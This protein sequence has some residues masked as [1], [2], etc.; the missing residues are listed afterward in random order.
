M[1][2]R[3]EVSF[4][5][6]C[7]TPMRHHKGSASGRAE[8]REALER[9]FPELDLMEIEKSGRQQRLHTEDILDACVA[10]WS[11]RRLVNKQGR[12]LPEVVP[13]DRTGLPMAIWI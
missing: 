1:L 2:F 6:L 8:R 4:T 3:S 9:F 7:G 5:E 12:S 11:A 13:F 10:C